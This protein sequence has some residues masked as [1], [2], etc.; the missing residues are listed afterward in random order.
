MGVQNWAAEGGPRLGID[1][2]GVALETVVEFGKELEGLF[3]VGRLGERRESAAKG[4]L[5]DK[6]DLADS[7]GSAVNFEEAFLGGLDGVRSVDVGG[8]VGGYLFVYVNPNVV[9]SD[10]R[11]R[12]DDV[13]AVGLRGDV[14]GRED[15][16]RRL[17]RHLGDLSKEL[18][19]G[20][21]E[22]VVA[23]K[24]VAVGLHVVVSSLE[25][26]KRPKVPGNDSGVVVNRALR[27]PP[28]RLIRLV[29]VLDRRVDGV[30]PPH[31]SRVGES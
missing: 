22:G 8:N 16:E 21:V 30:R 5:E 26:E 4:Q 29:E 27:L 28:P 18:G 20:S 9:F 31:P 11:E 2:A 23:E 12:Y 1:D 24:E 6:G 3:E 25:R 7:G 17:R 13:P 19:R 15:A 10:G 14:P